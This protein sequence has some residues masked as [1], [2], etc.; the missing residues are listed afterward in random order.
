M[1]NKIYNK[2]IFIHNQNLKDKPKFVE[3]IYFNQQTKLKK[4]I[5]FIKNNL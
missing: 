4:Q 2:F 3:L 5:Y 1:L